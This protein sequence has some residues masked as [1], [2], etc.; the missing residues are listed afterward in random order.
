[1]TIEQDQL[2]VTRRGLRQKEAMHFIILI[3]LCH[4]EAV[5]AEAI[6]PFQ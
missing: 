2:T 1:M 6:P 4:C 5:F 3:L